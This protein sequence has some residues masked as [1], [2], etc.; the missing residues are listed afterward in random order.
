MA[1]CS[2]VREKSIT[3]RRSLE[4]SD[5]VVLDLGHPSPDRG[6]FERSLGSVEVLHRTHLEHGC[7]KEVAEALRV[8]HGEWINRATARGFVSA[9]EVLSAAN[10]PD[11]LLLDAEAPR[12]HADVGEVLMGVAEVSELPVEVDSQ[13]LRSDEVVAGSVIAVNQAQLGG[14]RLALDAPAKC[15]LKGRA[16]GCAVQEGSRD[17]KLLFDGP[18]GQGRKV[19][20]SESVDPGECRPELSGEGIAGAGER[21]VPH[22]DV[23]PSLPLDAFHDEAACQDRKR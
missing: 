7:G 3:G 19:R 21:W 1:R 13:A 12:A 17:G 16:R 2:S 22:E 15:H 11:L 14:H 6:S 4:E 10:A 9:I 23:R 20:L 18:T 5:E 8:A